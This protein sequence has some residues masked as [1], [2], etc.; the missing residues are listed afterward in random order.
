MKEIYVSLSDAARV[1]QFV[2]TLTP[3]TGDFE[4]VSDHCV[5]DGRSMM[6]IFSFD[7][8]RPIMLKVYNDCE[9]NLKALNP[10]LSKT[11]VKNHE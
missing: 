9:E 4:L 1:Q 2:R 5:L 11:E 3:L 8:S 6:G 10:F 7:L